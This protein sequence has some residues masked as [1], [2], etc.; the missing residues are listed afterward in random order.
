METFHLKGTLD[1]FHLTVDCGLM[2]HLCHATIVHQF[3]QH[4]LQLD[5]DTHHQF[6]FFTFQIQEKVLLVTL[7]A[8]RFKSIREM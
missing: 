8:M 2:P 1:V 4:V 3:G 6:P 7:R 5:L